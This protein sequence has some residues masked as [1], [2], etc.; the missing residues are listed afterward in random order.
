MSP[1]GK[2]ESCSTQAIDVS[3][4]EVEDKLLLA[5]EMKREEKAFLN[6]SIDI[7]QAL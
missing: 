7:R 2:E 5:V 6:P 4:I 3:V 1:A